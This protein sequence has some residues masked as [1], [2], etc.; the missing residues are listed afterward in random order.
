MPRATGR[1]TNSIYARPATTA[2]RG[3]NRP[4][5]SVRGGPARAPAA[6][7][8]PPAVAEAP[9]PVVNNA[10]L[11]SADSLTLKTI[12]EQMTQFAVGLTTA[13]R[14]CDTTQLMMVEQLGE[15]R[16][17]IA[18]NRTAAIAESRA[19]HQ[20]LQQ[21][22]THTAPSFIWRSRGHEA[23]HIYNCG[24]LN[25]YIQISTALESDDPE[26]AKALV[27]TGTKAIILR[28]KCIKLA[29]A[30]QAGWGLVDEYLSNKLADDDDDDKWI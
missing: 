4:A 19:L 3:F 22:F 15:Q 23:Q 11:L 28:N 24:T 9:A 8:A 29:D 1:R 20:T 21:Q 30:S 25:N 6:A 5:V 16:K 10:A 7:G 17:L 14:A 12:A 2:P 27:R 13:Q 18:E 26:E